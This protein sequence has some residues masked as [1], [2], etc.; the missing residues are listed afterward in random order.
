LHFFFRSLLV[1]GVLLNAALPWVAAVS[2]ELEDAHGSY[3]EE[4]ASFEFSEEVL[5]D[6]G[7][8]I[9]TAASQRIP[10]YLL[11]NGRLLPN[12]NRTIHVVPRFPGAIRESR[13]HVGDSV[14]K[15]EILAVIESNQSLQ[16]YELRSPLSGTVVKR[17]ASAGEFAAEGKDLFLVTDLSELWADFFLFPGDFG[18]VKKGQRVLILIEHRPEPVTS[19]VAFVSAV[20][21]EATQ[22]KVVRA[23]VRTPNEDL[24]P[25]QFITGKII[26][27]EDEVPLAVEAAAIQKLDGKSVVFVPDG[28]RVA[29]RAVVTGKSDGRYT[30]ILSGLSADAHYYTG[31]T[32]ILRAEAEK[33]TATH[34]D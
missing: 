26:A 32:F 17:H 23:E 30:E 25:G 28:N 15:G 34:E 5:A 14:E 1:L 12:E 16:P 9:A 2:E 19:E 27:S 4:D 31:N 13:K 22:S 11:L 3:H 21:D 7:L 8:S 20:L 33:G 18:T 29:R 6:S 10:Q 24:Y